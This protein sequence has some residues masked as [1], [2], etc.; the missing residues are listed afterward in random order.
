S[1]VQAAKRLRSGS[2]GKPARAGAER[3]MQESRAISGSPMLKALIIA[4]VLLATLAVAQRSQQLPQPRQPSQWCPVGCASGPAWLGDSTLM[5]WYR[6]FYAPR[7]G[8]AYDSH[9]RTAGIAG[10]TRPRRG[11]RVAAGGAWAAGANAAHWHAFALLRERFSI[12]GPPFGVPS[13]AA[14]IGLD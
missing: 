5:A 1:A 2:A 13:G 12:K 8:G 3:K 14:E 10:R 6:W 4:T 11:G 7:T 9:H